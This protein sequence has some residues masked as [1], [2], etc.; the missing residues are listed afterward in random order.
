MKKIF[1]IIG[2][3]AMMMSLGLTSCGDNDD[4]SNPH[5]LSD[6]EIA[7]MKRQDSI[8]QAQLNRIDADLVLE[9]T[10]EDYPSASNWTN[11]ALDIDLDAI[12]QVF[13]LTKQEVKDG[14]NQETGA[15]DI[16]GFAILASSHAD[17]ATASTTNGTW[18]HWWNTDG[19]LCN[20]YNDANSALFCEWNGD[21][22][23]VGQ[24]P[25][26]LTAGQEITVI[27]GLKYGDKRV[28]VKITFKCVARE[29]VK[30]TIVDTKELKAEFAVSSDSYDGTHVDLDIKDILAKLGV[31]SVADVDV[32]G[33]AAD[34]GYVQEYTAGAGYW[35]DKDGYPCAYGD[36]ALAFIE[37]Y[38]NQEGAE[39]GDDLYLNIG[40]YPGHLT[41]GDVIAMPIGFLANNKIVKVVVTL[42]AKEEVK[43][44]PAE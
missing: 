34:G 23:T 6:D 7:E 10:V 41:A 44:Q 39:E 24:F 18:G 16:K 43:T 25:G 9:Y 5:V 42:T 35:Y 4:I 1:L 27:E 12:G 31:S 14:I 20:K 36:D 33:F 2:A 19:D 22:F 30:A 26:H 40:Q 32:I 38:G 37:Y 3:F 8:K 17:V 13:G 21:N 15:A 29:E 28:A 11:K